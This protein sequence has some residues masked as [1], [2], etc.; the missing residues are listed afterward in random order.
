[1][2]SQTSL[3]APDATWPL[4]ATLFVAIAV[5]HFAERTRI[6]G[7]LSAALV[8]ML[9]TFGLSNLGV[10]PSDAPLYAM[11]WTYVVPIAIPLLL[12]HADVRKLVRL[13]GPM[14]LAYGIGVGATVVGAVVAYA[15]VD[16][17]DGWRFAGVFT[18]TYTGGSMNFFGA[19]DALELQSGDVLTAAIAAD[20]LVAL[21]FYGVLFAL[22]AVPLAQRLFPARAVGGLG[23]QESHAHVIERPD[24]GDMATSFAIAASIC[25]AGIALTEWMGAPQMAILAVSALVLVAATALP[26]TMGRVRGGGELGMYLMH[27]LFAV[28]GAGAHIGAVVRTG[29]ALFVFAGIILAVHLV[30]TLSVARV[31]RL[32]LPEVLLASNACVGGP[33]TAAA[34]ATACGWE[35]LMVPSILC[36]TLGY[37]AATF[38]GVAIAHGLRGLA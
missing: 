33:T 32:G 30:V 37:S 9:V 20:S 34:M 26:R 38:L 2:T 12:F 8:T 18:A 25:A 6:G 31:M 22:P 5:G 23:H 24:R 16:L 15:I 28:I 14:L 7:R 27:L 29:A 3:I 19:A 35:R 11:I 1:M 13:S 4:L 36:G 21:M 17:P 10:I